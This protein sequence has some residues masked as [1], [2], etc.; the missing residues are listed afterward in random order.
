MKRISLYFCWRCRD[1]TF[2]FSSSLK[3]V[4]KSSASVSSQSSS[5]CATSSFSSFSLVHSAVRVKIWVEREREVLRS[6]AR[7]KSAREKSNATPKKFSKTTLSSSHPFVFC[8]DEIQFSPMTKKTNGTHL[9]LRTPRTRRRTL[10]PPALSSSVCSRGV[11]VVSLG[12]GRFWSEEA[13]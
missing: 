10:S 12:V 11:V 13:S 2:F 4:L 5:H 9:L 6:L 1:A 7:R 3:C 8:D